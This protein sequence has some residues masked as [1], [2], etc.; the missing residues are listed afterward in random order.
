MLQ[1]EFEER[2]KFEV[3]ADCYHK[4]IDPEYN[5]SQL[6]K[7]EWVK[8]WKKNG[9]IQKAYDW[10]RTNR[11][12]AEKSA[13]HT[14]EILDS[15]VEER[16]FYMNQAKEFCDRKEELDKENETLKSQVDA[17]NNEAKSIA[18]F[19]VKRGTKNNDLSLL[20][21][22]ATILGEKDYIDYKLKNNIELNEEDK[23][24]IIRN[25]K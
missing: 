14:Q 3:S 11:Q 10:E 5:A 25:L 16:D 15:V 6:D 1:K 20:H 13:K 12:L 4:C 22:A 19:M 2:V 8:E 23:K 24:I 21:E 17:L 9:G 18:E 7:D